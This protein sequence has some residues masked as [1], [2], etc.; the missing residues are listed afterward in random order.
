MLRPLLE[1]LLSYLPTF[2]PS[3]IFDYIVYESSDDQLI[4][5]THL[6]LPSTTTIQLTFLK[7][8]S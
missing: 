1:E 7:T 6:F 8:Y 3:H 4:Q 5:S 2:F